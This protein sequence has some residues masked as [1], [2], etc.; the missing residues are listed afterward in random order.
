MKKL[1]LGVLAHVDAGKTTL[2]EALLYTCGSIRKLG[3]VDH[4]NT[5]LDT[6]KIERE[7]GITVFSKQ[8]QLRTDNMELC[9]LDT[10]G[11]ADLTAE[12]ERT[13]DVIDYALLVISERIRDNIKKI[14]D[15]TVPCGSVDIRFYRDDLTHESDQP[16][17]TKA[18]IGADV[19]DKN[20][21]LVDDVLYTGRTARAAIEAVFTA[22]R[23]RSIQ[24]A[25][26]VDRGHRELPIR[27][28]YVGKNVPTSRAELI[29]VRL[30]EFDG[31]TGV[32]LME[33]E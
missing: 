8:A 27:A 21:V 5:A 31:E 10:P 28:D 32:Y 16:V 4:R 20:V 7:R 23:P 1:V 15:A 14:E 30:P 33:I 12:T 6:H 25:V 17:I 18:D 24:F 9:L 26:L 3:R 29:E 13:L 2:S 19:N 11:H 22:G